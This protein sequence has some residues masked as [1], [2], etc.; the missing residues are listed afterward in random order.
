MDRTGGEKMAGKQKI[1]AEMTIKGGKI[2][3]DLNGLA[4]ETY[5]D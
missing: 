4:V 2:V 3:W 1:E 5:K